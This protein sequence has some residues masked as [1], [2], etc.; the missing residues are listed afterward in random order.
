[1]LAA[2]EAAHVTAHGRTGNSSSHTGASLSAHTRGGANALAISASYPRRPLPL[3]TSTS[4][5]F[6]TLTPVLDSSVGKPAQGV[7]VELS[8]INGGQAQVLATG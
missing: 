7:K 2:A 3:P 5:S 4:P 8:Q 1:V 6:R